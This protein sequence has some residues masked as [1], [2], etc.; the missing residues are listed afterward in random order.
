MTLPDVELTSATVLIVDWLDSH[1]VIPVR[2][3]VPD[4]RPDDFIL[5]RRVGGVPTNPVTDEPMFTIES[6]RMGDPVQAEEDLLTVRRLM[7]GLRGSS[8]GGRPVYRVDEI[9]GPGYLPD[10]DSDHD[11]YTMTVVIGIRG[12]TS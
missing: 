7:A 2:A 10:P 3:T 5:V 6:W 9:A 12:I 8:I 4:P 1:F 11:R